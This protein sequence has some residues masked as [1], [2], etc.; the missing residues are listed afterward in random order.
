MTLTAS[1]LLRTFHEGHPSEDI[2]VWAD[3]HTNAHRSPAPTA[4]GMVNSEA[5]ISIHPNGFLAR[6]F[7]IW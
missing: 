4:N 7:F 2:S 5:V 1:F 3:P 6:L